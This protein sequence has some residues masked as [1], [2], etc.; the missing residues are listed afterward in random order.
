VI[1]AA[2]RGINHPLAKVIR[3]RG[4]GLPDPRV[5]A[6]KQARRDFYQTGVDPLPIADTLST[7]ALVQMFTYA[8]NGGSTWDERDTWHV[9]T[10]L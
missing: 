3:H 8:I 1:E 10:Y 9:T 7:R 4:G 6:V 5:A 2:L